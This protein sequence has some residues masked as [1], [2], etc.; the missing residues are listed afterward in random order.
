MAHREPHVNIWLQSNLERSKP[1]VNVT[2][3]IKVTCL[4]KISPCHWGLFLA[5]LV[6]EWN[7]YQLIIINTSSFAVSFVFCQDFF[8][9]MWKWGVKLGVFLCSSLMTN[10]CGMLL[11]SPLWVWFL[12]FLL[13]LL[14]S[15]SFLWFPVVSHYTDLLSYLCFFS[16]SLYLPAVQYL[17]GLKL[18][19]KQRVCWSLL[20]AAVLCVSQEFCFH[21]S[22]FLC[23]GTWGFIDEWNN[24]RI[25]VKLC[26]SVVTPSTLWEVC[27]CQL[28]FV[29]SSRQEPSTGTGVSCGQWL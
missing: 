20:Q 15:A 4:Q 16:G 6:S 28:V 11:Y 8:S 1:H 12:H 5:F 14:T 27:A 25:W 18:F 9:E 17:Y 7:I 22:G 10:I 19:R 21:L 3:V 24:C 26:I 13:L 2:Q 23:G 29:S